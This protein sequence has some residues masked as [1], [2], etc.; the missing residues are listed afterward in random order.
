MSERYRPDVEQK[1]FYVDL[2][3]ARA[4]TANGALEKFKADH[5]DK[6]FFTA[7]E[8]AQLLGVHYRTATI[9]IKRLGVRKYQYHNASRSYVIDGEELHSRMEDDSFGA[10]YLLRIK[11]R[12]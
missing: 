10:I 4:L 11:R 2:D 1:R 6:N 7:S 9:V 5:P 8:L 12:S 3:A